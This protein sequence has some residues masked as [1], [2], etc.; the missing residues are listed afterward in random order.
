MHDA[1]AGYTRYTPTVL[2]AEHET[3][4]TSGFQQ[5]ALFLDAAFISL[6]TRRS[7]K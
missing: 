4:I 6:R 5:Q 3:L 1:V 7:T 2:V